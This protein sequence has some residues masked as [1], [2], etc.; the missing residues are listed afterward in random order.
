MGIGIMVE[1]LLLDGQVEA[2]LALISHLYRMG[3][4][5]EIFE[6]KEVATLDVYLR[7]QAANVGNY[8]LLG[9]PNIDAASLHCHTRKGLKA[10]K[11]RRDS[12]GSSRKENVLIVRPS[13][14]GDTKNNRNLENLWPRVRPDGAGGRMG[15]SLCRCL[16]AMN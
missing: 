12:A 2:A 3:K 14:S 5:P 7:R 9:Q 16:R 1:I 10:L 6:W 11:R 8:G 15:W 13:A 4:K